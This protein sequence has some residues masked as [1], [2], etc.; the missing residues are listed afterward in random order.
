MDRGE[1]AS[2]LSQVQDTNVNGN[3]DSI[4][5]DLRHGH[6]QIANNNVSEWI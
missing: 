3:A 4:S 1:R 6:A 5:F 2:T